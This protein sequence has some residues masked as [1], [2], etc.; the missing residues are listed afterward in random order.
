MGRAV[1]GPANATALGLLA[2]HHCSTAWQGAAE[3]QAC[4]RCGSR[5]H[6]RKPASLQRTWALLLAAYLMY[7]P[8]NL[9]PVMVTS[10]LINTQVDTILSGIIYFWV[11]GA[12]HLAV[13]VFVASFLVPLF[14][15]AALTTLVVMAQRRSRARKLERARLYRVVEF[16]GRW[17]MLDVFVVSLMAGLVRIDGIAEVSAGP[18]IAAFGAVV[19]LTMLASLSFDPRLIWDGIPL[20][21][22]AHP[23]LPLPHDPTHV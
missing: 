14:K 13:I 3:G 22:R 11:T 20:A 15:L 18:G 19:V 1:S 6:R 2:C 8:A 5:L 9:L 7:L 12:W 17:S 23:S 4:A 21:D 10:S 16:I